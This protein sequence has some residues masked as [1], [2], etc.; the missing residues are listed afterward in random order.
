M[1]L[2]KGSLSQDLYSETDESGSEG[3]EAS[4]DEYYEDDED[5]EYDEED[6]ESDYESEDSG[7]QTDEDSGSVSSPNRN[8]DDGSSVHKKVVCP[9]LIKQ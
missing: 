2:Q 5:E 1:S 9:H 4:D 8:V 7:V 3:E 6:D